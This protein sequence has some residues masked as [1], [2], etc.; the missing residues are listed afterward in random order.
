MPPMPSMLLVTKTT[1]QHGWHAYR[2]SIG[3]P[4]Y[5]AGYRRFPSAFTSLFMNSL[6][7]FHNY[8]AR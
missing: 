8:E 7:N 1:W 6:I 3:R 5:R 2:Q 4:R